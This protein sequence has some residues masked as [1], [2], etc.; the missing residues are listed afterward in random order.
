MFEKTGD[1]TNYSG[2]DFESWECR[3]GQTH[4]EHAILEKS[5]KTPTERK[6]LSSKY[7]A[8]FSELHRL[9][10]FDPVRMHTVDPMHNLFLGTANHVFV[11][12]IDL[13]ILDEEKLKKIDN[14]MDLIKVPTDIGRIPGI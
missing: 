1:H 6:E 5:G 13:G 8:R 14:S 7:G 3:T 10:Y 11:T 9:P 12:W 2:Y 4:K